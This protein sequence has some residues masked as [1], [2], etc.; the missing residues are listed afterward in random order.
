MRSLNLYLQ[1]PN[2]DYAEVVK[3]YQANFYNITKPKNTRDLINFTSNNTNT[4][5]ISK[6]DG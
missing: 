5:L 1:L 4:N 6:L 3:D 2:E